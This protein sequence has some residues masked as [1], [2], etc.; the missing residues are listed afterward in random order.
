MSFLRFAGLVNDATCSLEQIV[1]HTRVV[2]AGMRKFQALREW[3]D[4]VKII[5]LN[6]PFKHKLKHLLVTFRK[7]LK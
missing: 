7:E 1:Q 6:F 5:Y 3:Q 4:S 2:L